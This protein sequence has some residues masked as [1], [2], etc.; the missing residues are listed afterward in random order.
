MRLESSAKQL[1]VIRVIRPPIRKE[2]KTDGPAIGKS[3]PI[4][5]KKLAPMFAPRP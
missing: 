3:I 4:I 1:A 2:I 5:K